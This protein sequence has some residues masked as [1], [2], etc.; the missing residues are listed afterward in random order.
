MQWR[1]NEEGKWGLATWAQVL[2]V[3][4]HTLQ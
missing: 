2:R 1:N 3:H 4:Q